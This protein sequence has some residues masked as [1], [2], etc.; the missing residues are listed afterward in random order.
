VLHSFGT[1]PTQ[2]SHVR[3]DQRKGTLYGTTGAGG[4]YNAGTSSVSLPAARKSALQLHR[5]ADGDIPQAGLIGVGQ[6]LRYNVY[7]GHAQQWHGFSVTSR[8]RAESS[9]QLPTAMEEMGVS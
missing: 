7:W 4:A 5:G 1:E 3:P 2:W 6:A 9:S 8:G